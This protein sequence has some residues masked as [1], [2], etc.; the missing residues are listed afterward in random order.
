MPKYKGSFIAKQIE[1]DIG[2]Y[3]RDKARALKL[4]ALRDAYYARKRGESNGERTEFSAD[5]L[6]NTTREAGDIKE[7]AKG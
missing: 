5:G 6:E 4:K 3:E 1:D 7:R 2:R